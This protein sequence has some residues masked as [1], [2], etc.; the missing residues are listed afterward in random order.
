MLMTWILAWLFYSFNRVKKTVFKK[1]EG[2]LLLSKTLNENQEQ[3]IK[4][5]DMRFQ[6]VKEGYENEKNINVDQQKTLQKN[7]EQILMLNK[8]LATLTAD[9]RS[10]FDK[11]D[12]QMNTFLEMKMN[13]QLEF[14]NLANQLLEEKAKKF[15]EEQKRGLNEVLNPLKEKIKNF[16]D[17]IEVSNKESLARHVSLKEQLV[18]LRDLNEKMTTEASN[19]TRALK[20][21][22]KTQGAWGE[23][24][25]ESILDKSGLRKDSEYFIQQ[26]LRDSNGKL[27]RPDV[28][29]DLPDGKK[30]MIDSKVSLTAYERFINA[31]NDDEMILAAKENALSIKKHID[32]LSAKNYHDLYAIESPDFV[33][34]FIPIETAF[35][36]ALKQNSDLY[37]Y[38]FD[39]N[40]V[41]V[42]PS[43]LLAT[44]KTVDSLWQNDKQQ[45]N[46]LAIASEAGKMYDK[47]ASFVNDMEIIGK[48]IGQ[49]QHAFDESMRKLHS[50]SGNLISRADKLKKLGAKANKNLTQ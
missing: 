37:L 43:T 2:E 18:G 3:K 36:A 16:E 31:N 21:D 45:K 4:E 15:D 47:F 50:G 26:S 30:I 23:L 46:A 48:R 38:A 40:I 49:T 35:S 34:M 7:Q 11:L 19:L 42:T 44:L 17:K 10:L 5:L 39:K 6:F 29:I 13:S 8:E 33:L 32:G 22:T 41:V 20:Q 9:N 1:L 28:I 12:D 25:L 27:F 24:I 14:K